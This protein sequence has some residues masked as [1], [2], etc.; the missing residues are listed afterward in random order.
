MVAIEED[1]MPICPCSLA[2]TP[3]SKQRA[4]EEVGGRQEMF[5]V[6]VGFLRASGD[7]HSVENKPIRTGLRNECEVRGF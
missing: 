7:T 6:K 4:I 2:S 3:G 5:E 1:T